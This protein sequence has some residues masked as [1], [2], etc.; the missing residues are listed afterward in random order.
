MRRVWEDNI[1][2]MCWEGSL[3]K[4]EENAICSVMFKSI[5][6]GVKPLGSSWAG[7]G[8]SE[9]GVLQAREGWKPEQY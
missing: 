4:T 1:V 2:M 3:R 9:Y 7:K 6:I 8:V 5:V